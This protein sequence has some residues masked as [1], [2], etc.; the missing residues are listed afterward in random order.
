MVV[1]T[2]G[3]HTPALVVE[4]GAAQ[5]APRP[6]PWASTGGYG[7]SG[8][9]GDGDADRP[10]KKVS[11]RR[12]RQGTCITRPGCTGRGTLAH[13]QHRVCAVASAVLAVV[14]ALGQEVDGT[15]MLLL[16]VSLR[17]PGL[18]SLRSRPPPRCPELP[19]KQ[20]AHFGVRDCPGARES[21]RRVGR[22]HQQPGGSPGGAAARRGAAAGA[23]S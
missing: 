8:G 16:G 19:R 5:P 6:A 3:D 1:D 18:L 10:V 23:A 7:G 9:R 22:V 15:A 20:I 12:R 17:A 14:N 4:A 13:T 11:R 2:Q 21:T